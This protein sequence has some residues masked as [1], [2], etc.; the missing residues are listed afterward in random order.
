MIVF[1][2]IAV[3]GTL[4]TAF[5]FKYKIFDVQYPEEP[6][7]L[8]SPKTV[9][10]PPITPKPPE[11]MPELVKPVQTKRE[12]LY[13]V[14]KACIGQD[15][16]PQDVAPDTLACMESVDG[17]YLKAFGKHLL[18]PA[19]R[20]S[21]MLGYKAMLNNPELEVVADPL[22]GDI[23]ISPTGYSSKNSP[24]GHTGLRGISTYMSNDSDSGL[25]KA[26]YTLAAWPL[27]FSKTLGFSVIHF[28]VKGDMIS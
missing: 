20:Y 18:S 9:P 12:H 4:A 5:G 23:V 28:R 11:P 13:E 17:V 26:N 3:L 14:A 8:Q 19:N 10:E 25:W 6:E 24:H 21:T 16:S 15:M 1:I 22:P 27:V 7:P 2:V